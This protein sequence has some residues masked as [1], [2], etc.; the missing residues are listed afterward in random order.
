VPTHDKEDIGLEI[1]EFLEQHTFIRWR[2]RKPI[3]DTRR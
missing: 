2:K 1:A 3:Y